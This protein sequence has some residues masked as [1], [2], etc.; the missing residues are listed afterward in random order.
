MTDSSAILGLD[1]HSRYSPVHGSKL[2]RNGLRGQSTATSS[3]STKAMCLSNDCSGTQVSMNKAFELRCY[4]SRWTGVRS[5]SVKAGIRRLVLTTSPHANVNTHS[6]HSQ[7][8]LRLPFNTFTKTKTPPLPKKKKNHKKT[9]T[10]NIPQH[11]QG[12]G[13]KV[14]HVF[15]SILKLNPNRRT[16]C[17]HLLIICSMLDN[18]DP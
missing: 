15:T 11:R 7:Y 13:K 18:R 1:S 4:I 6:P 17:A 14:F 9:K 8:S 2:Y 5:T 10:K 12:Q 3:M 16:C